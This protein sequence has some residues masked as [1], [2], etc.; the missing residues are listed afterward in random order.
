MV[1]ELCIIFMKNGHMRESSR[2]IKWKEKEFLS[3]RMERSFKD[4][5]AKANAKKASYSLPVDK[6]WMLMMNDDSRNFNV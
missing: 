3:G 1:Q 2:K 4:L 5:S 6:L